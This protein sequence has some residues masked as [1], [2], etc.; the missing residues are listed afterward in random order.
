[1]HTHLEIAIPID[2]TT[3]GLDSGEEGWV[4]IYKIL[5]AIANNNCTYVSYTVILVLKPLAG[6]KVA[7]QE[8]S[9]LGHRGDAYVS[10]IICDVLGGTS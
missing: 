7:K 9:E 8:T 4:G 3:P 1:M 5:L 2:D 10:T 6:R